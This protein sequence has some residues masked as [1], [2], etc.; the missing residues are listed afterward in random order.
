MAERKK[1]IRPNLH[2][3]KGLKQLEQLIL[4]SPSPEGLLKKLL[5][6]VHSSPDKI[7]T[8]DKQGKLSHRNIDSIHFQELVESL[9]D[10]IWKVNEFGVYTY[11][12]PQI[13]NLL[14]YEPDEALGKTPFDFM[15]EEEAKRV[16][17]LFMDF[18]K[19]RQPF[20]ALENINRTCD[21]DLIVLETS[22]VPIFDSQGRFSGYQGVDRD[23]TERKQIEKELSESEKSYKLLVENQNELVVKVDTEGRFLYVSPSYCKT[24]GKSEEELL[25]KSFMPLVHEEDREP[26][27]KAMK[28]LH[29]PPYTAF[30]EQRA[31]TVAG[32]RWLAWSDK[33]IVDENGQ[34]ETIIGVGKDITSRKELEAE[35]RATKEKLQ[36]IIDTS[37][38]WIWEIDLAGRHTFSNL[39]VLDFLGYQ[40]KEITEI[41]YYSLLHEDDFRELKQKLPRFID[42]RRGWN[43]WVLRWRHRDG[44]YRFLESNSKPVFNSAGELVGYRGA[45]RDITQRKESE[46]VLLA[47]T[48]AAEAANRTKSVF[49]AKVSHEIRTPMTAIVGFGELLEETELTS[50]QQ[51]YLSLINASSKTLAS[52]LDDVIDLSKIEAGVLTVKPKNFILRNIVDKSVA[53]YEQQIAKKNLHLNVCIDQDIPESL[54]GD[55]LRIQQVLL[56]ILGNAV[57]FTESGGVSVE[58]SLAE[59][60]S[61]RVLLDIAVKDTGIGIALEDQEKI[62]EPFTQALPFNSH[63]YGG[64]GLGLS[65]SRSLASLMGGSLHVESEEGVGSCFHLLVPLRSQSSS[66][67]QKSLDESE[68]TTWTGPVLDIL[69][70]EDNPINSQLIKTVLKNMGHK[71]TVVDNGKGALEA[72]NT[73]SFNLLL[74]DIQMPVMDGTSALKAIRKF[75][76]NSGNHLIVIAITAYASIGDQEKYLKMGFDGYL[77]KP[78]R[79][80]ELFDELVRIMPH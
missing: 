64:S 5:K 47:A 72:L 34:I 63:N 28:N 68:P 70:A 10:W 44:S 41:N 19:K 52:L 60:T 33:A 80:K 66:H 26:T 57:K 11:V 12:S 40:P 15:P 43:G 74:M 36:N 55:P 65:I 13:K 51:K 18:V 46:E 62:F 71:V 78:I 45:D 75:E 53:T 54:I 16:R 27:A 23:I 30:I 73:K 38:E 2:L 67:S 7:L 56:N 58:I 8:Y 76:Q 21:G 31:M 14:G 50:E 17:S 22:G 1:K 9:N 6:I 35:R 25:G 49:M 24:F 39:R 69:L 79:T 42:Q 61:Q 32:W 37:S 29:H 48:E 77:S 4:S 20:N 59:E 3:S